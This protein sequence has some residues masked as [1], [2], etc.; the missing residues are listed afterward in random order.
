MQSSF[1]ATIQEPL[2]HTIVGDITQEVLSGRFNGYVKIDI[3]HFYASIDHR[4]LLKKVKKII[5]KAEAIHFLEEASF[6]R[7]NRTSW[8]QPHKEVR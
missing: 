5:R 3:T 7:N 2:L 6:Y 8:L 4:L 1:G